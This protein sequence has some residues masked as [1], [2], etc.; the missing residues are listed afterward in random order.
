MASEALTKLSVELTDRYLYFGN[1]C[2]HE[3]QY[4]SE[5]WLGLALHPTHDRELEHDARQ[6]LPVP[7]GSVQKIQSQDVFEHIPYDVLPPIL[8]DIFRALAVGGVFRLSL[9]DYRSPYLRKR[10]VYDEEGRVIADLRM[11]GSVKYDR[12]T[13]QRRVEFAPNGNAH[14]WFP[15]FELVQDLVARSRLR[16]CRDVHYYQY[17]RTRKEFVAEPIPENEMFVQRALPHDNRAGGKPVSIV[18]DF[19]K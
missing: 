15:T 9:P 11:G 18:V 17:F 13:K 10:C 12:V 5:K 16:E 7:D 1:L 19:T 14:V 4:Q 6:P 2:T 8:D 3:R